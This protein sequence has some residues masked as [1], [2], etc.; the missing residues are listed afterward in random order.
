[1]ST[2]LNRADIHKVILD[3]FEE[4]REAKGVPYEP[5][6][7]LAFLTL[8]PPAPGRRAA[9]TFSGRRR[10]VRFVDSLQ[11]EL[12]IC[13]TNEELEPG[14]GLTELV[15]VAEA[16][17]RN[18][19]QARRLA[20]RRKKE[21]RVALTDEPLKFGILAGC[22]LAFPAVVGGP[23]LRVLAVLL[24]TATVAAVVTVDARHFRYAQKLV[25]RTMGGAG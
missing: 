20:A 25:E 23:L 12:G 9:D 2:A 17:L 6:R 8:R 19:E 3:V 10:F 24:W 14:F 13:F 11:L 21:A 22:I 4:A 18:P 1:M 16:K 7:F 15:D 5:D